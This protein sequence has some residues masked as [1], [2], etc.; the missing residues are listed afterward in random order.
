MSSSEPSRSESPAAAA[1]S[2]GSGDSD[3]DL[4]D[5]GVCSQTDADAPAGVAPGALVWACHRNKFWPAEVR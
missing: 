2:D 3:D 1:A 5:T 4:V